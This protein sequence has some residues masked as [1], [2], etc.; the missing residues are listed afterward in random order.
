[1]G[2]ACEQGIPEDEIAEAIEV[3]KIVRQRA[4]GKR[5]DLGLDVLGQTPSKS[6][7]A[8]CGCNW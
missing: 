7:A 8:G 2:K 3:G 1:M 4:Q 5:D 6:T